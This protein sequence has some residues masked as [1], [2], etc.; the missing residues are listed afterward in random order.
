MLLVSQVVASQSGYEEKDTSQVISAIR[1]GDVTKAKLIDRDQRVEVE[2]TNGDKIQ[3]EYIEPQGATIAQ[4]LE[5]NPPPE[6]YD[7]EVPQQSLLV[8]F[9]LSLLPIVLLVV[10]F[11][12]LMNQMQGGGSRVM[13]F[14][15]SKAKVVSKDTPQT[16]FA[17]VAGADEAVEELQEIKEF[18][19]EPA[20]FQAVGAKIPKGV[21]LYGPP[22]TG[23]TLL[24]RAVAGEAGVPVLLDLRLRLRR[25]VRRCRRL[26]G[27]RPVRAGEDERSGDRV[28]RRD[29]R[30][31]P[32]PWRRSRRRPRRARADAEPAPGR[33][34]RLRR[35]GRRDPDRR[36]QP[37]G[38]PR[39][40]PAASRPLRPADRGRGAGPR[41]PTEDPQRARQGQADRAGGRPA[42][43]GSP[44]AG[45]HRRRP[46]ERA[47]RG[48]AAH[49][50]HQ[51]AVRRPAS[52]G[53]GDRPGRGRT[54]EAQPG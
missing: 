10:L 53:R 8:T 45:L 28:R 19:Q 38:H 16:T 44:D 1:E 43:S 13:N 48:G 11:L 30:R 42:S 32:A 4:L 36:D 46:G 51:Q 22:G 25:D 37:A 39:P 20:K 35:Q 15:K 23:K 40:G 54:A 33:D 17:D 3:S 6:G 18:L 31:R 12:F 21:L 27:P 52:H 49:R 29:R 47:Q 41:G 34:G 2:L 50:P 14:G 9:L 7:A 24:A 26:P 5:D